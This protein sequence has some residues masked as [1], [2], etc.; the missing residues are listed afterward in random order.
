VLADGLDLAFGDLA[1]VLDAP[2]EIAYAAFPF[3]LL[4]GVVE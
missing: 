4:A 3:G 2:H 1:H